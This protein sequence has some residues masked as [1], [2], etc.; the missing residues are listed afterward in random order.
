MAEFYKEARPF[1]TMV[2]HD[3]SN[4]PVNSDLIFF[5]TAYE[6]S[7]DDEGKITVTLGCSTCKKGFESVYVIFEIFKFF[8]GE[9]VLSLTLNKRRNI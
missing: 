2:R 4:V 3:I 7:A 8:T 1:D 9:N 5:F 6:S